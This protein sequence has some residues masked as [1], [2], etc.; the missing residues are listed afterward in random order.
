MATPIYP[1]NW[2]LPTVPTISHLKAQVSTVKVR[3]VKE[4]ALRA[5]SKSQMLEKGI[6]I[7]GAG[8]KTVLRAAER[9]A[10]DYGG[11]P[12][13]WAKMTSKAFNNGIRQIQTHRYENVVNGMRVEQKTKTL[14]K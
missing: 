2:Y 13:D 11:K 10:N 7:A 1:I 12:A 14:K 8:T 4:P 6:P 9:L 3:S 5:A